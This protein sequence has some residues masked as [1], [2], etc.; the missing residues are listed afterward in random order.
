M[1]PEPAAPTKPLTAAQ[2]K[3]QAR[4]AAR[5]A[6]KAAERA[7]ASAIDDGTDDVAEALGELK[8]A[9]AAAG[10]GSGGGGGAAGGEASSGPVDTAK[11]VC[12]WRTSR[13]GC[14]TGLCLVLRVV[15]CACFLQDAV[16]YCSRHN[17]SWCL[18]T[19]DLLLSPL[20]VASHQWQAHEIDRP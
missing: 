3:N 12:F 18:A 17:S 4:A 6:K 14:C 1:A 8:V 19:R 13:G 16:F 2:R 9:G 11:K 10:G 7:S 20:P 15:L 5:K